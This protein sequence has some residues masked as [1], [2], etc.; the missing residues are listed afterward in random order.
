LTDRL[1]IIQVVAP[2]TAGGLER[3]V[4]SLAIGH[5]RRGHEVTAAT[6]LFGDEPRHPFV[7]TL[8]D[9][10]VRVH[11]IR[12][13][14]RQ[15]L[16][17]RRAVAGLC[18][19]ERPDVVHTHGYRIDLLDRGVIASLGLRTVTTVHGVS[20]MGGLKGAF[21][22][23]LQRRNYRRFDAVVAVSR[24]LHEA[25][26]AE[27]VDPKKLHLVPNAWSGL[28]EPLAPAAARRALGLPAEGK[29]VG[30]VGRFIQVKGGDVFLDA[31]R[32]LEA[33]PTAVLIG[34]GPEEKRLRQRATELGL[35][36]SVRFY[37]DVRD[38]AR[39]FPAFDA[40]V[41]SSRSE[42]LPIV[43]LE[44]MA[45]GV[46]VV[47]TSVGGV[48]EAVAEREGWLVPSEDPVALARAI[49]ASLADRSE[50]QTRATRARERLVREY[51]LEAFL[52][53]YE[54]VYRSVAG[55]AR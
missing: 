34:Y 28:R 27:G 6:L 12:L 1:K 50:A 4:E 43:L 45:A 3:V 32:L 40:W 26:L 13:T 31:L 16:L 24:A 17:E 53:R 29:V 49:Q 35:D 18:R 37:T 2:T 48:P 8:S 47:A 39:Y 36:E 51:S 19:T 54:A 33:R 44:A 10:G 21:F 14:P 7:E 22:E 55:K 30:W 11:P 20:K 23:W 25:T 46:P 52:D 42:G 15:Y 38:A 9:H 5:H 41:L